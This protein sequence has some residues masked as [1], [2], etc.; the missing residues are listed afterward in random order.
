[1]PTNTKNGIVMSLSVTEETPFFINLYVM[2][3]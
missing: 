3:F 2:H 1:L